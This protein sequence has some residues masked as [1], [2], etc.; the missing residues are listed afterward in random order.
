MTDDLYEPLSA[1]Q[2]TFKAAHA[3]NVSELFEELVRRSGVDERANA[4]TVAEVRALERRRDA[5]SESCG[6]WKLLRVCAV[7]FAVACAVGAVLSIWACVAPQAGLSPVRGAAGALA[8]LAGAAGSVALIV[9][10]V[11]ARIRAT[12]ARARALQEQ[13][14]RKTAEAWAQMAPLNRLYD[15]DLAAKM[16]MK[17]VPR[18]VLD[19]YFS[20]GRLDELRRAFGWDDGFNRDKSVLFAQSGALNGNPF[21]LAETLDFR[22]VQ[23][24]YTGSLSISWREQERGPDGKT[25]WVTRHQT[26]HA[27]VSKPAPDHTRHKFLIYGNEAAPTLTFS[28]EPSKL[29]APDDGLINKWRKGWEKSRLEALSR[30]LDDD[31]GFTL[32]ANSEFDL[33]FHAIDRSDEVQFRLLFTPLAQSQMVALL[34]DKTVGYGDDFAFVK[35]RM[36]NWIAPRHLDG[37]DISAAPSLFHNFDLAAARKRFNEYHNGYF[38][39]VFFAFAPLLAIP[40][41]QQHRSHASIYADVYGKTASF[42]EDEAIANYHGEQVF[43]H[44]ESVTANLLKT[45]LRHEENGVRTLSVTAHGFRGHRRTDYVEKLGGDGRFHRV[46][47]EWIEYEAVSRTSTLD[48]QETEGISQQD[49]D[50]LTGAADEWRERF[51]KWRAE[52]RRTVFRR[53]ILSCAASS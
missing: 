24:T 9:S 13:V 53:S 40:L 37:I 29:S 11:N 33:L 52:P 30:N 43:R 7:L 6:R 5:A 17:T 36:I 25:R 26:L 1:Y 49:Y 8:C 12:G 46:P 3:R 16:M 23:R 2:N 15:W 10:K 20:S 22:M 41:Y 35:S 44:P 32:M 48:V 21:V 50:R 31:K 28:R 4:A 38:K 14:S 45:A 27:S 42:W 39:A 47:V 51:T 18:L 34:K 19:P